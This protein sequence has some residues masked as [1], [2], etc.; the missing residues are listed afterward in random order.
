MTLLF[1]NLSIGEVVVIL[2]VA[3]LLFGPKQLVSTA[4]KI[5]KIVF[6][7]QKTTDNLKKEIAQQVNTAN[8]ETE[9]DTQIEPKE[10]NR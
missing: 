2:L 4:Q 7:I 10:T 5:G 3:L 1:L 8:K 9:P 6:N